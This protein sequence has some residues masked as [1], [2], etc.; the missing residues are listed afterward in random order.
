M[1]GGMFAACRSKQYDDFTKILRY[2]DVFLDKEKNL[3]FL[4]KI[5]IQTRKFE[6]KTTRRSNTIQVSSDN[7][8]SGLH[9]RTKNNRRVGETRDFESRTGDDVFY[10]LRGISS[11]FRRSLWFFAER[12]RNCRLRSLRKDCWLGTATQQQHP[13]IRPVFNRGE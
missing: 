9:S 6:R 11:L 12:R 1:F 2:K 10:R 8:V 13:T 3:F 5:R 7:H 4:S